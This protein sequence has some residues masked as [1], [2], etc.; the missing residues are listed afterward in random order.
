MSS[1]TIEKMWYNSVNPSELDHLIRIFKRNNNHFLV[2]SICDWMQRDI[3]AKPL[4]LY[5]VYLINEI[6]L[7]KI[8]CIEDHIKILEITQW[9]YYQNGVHLPIEECPYLKDSHVV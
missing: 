4:T 9:K 3:I 2:L 5:G 8:P 7:Y 6:G 1:H